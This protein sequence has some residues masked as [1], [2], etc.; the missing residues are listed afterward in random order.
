MKKIKEFKLT[1]SLNI[2]LNFCSLII[3]FIGLRFIEIDNLNNIFILL[4][5]LLLVLFLHELIHIVFYK[6]F[7]A[8]V[9]FGIKL[10]FY[11]YV[12]NILEKFYKIKEII[13][14]LISSCL[15]LSLLLYILCLFLP[16]LTVYLNLLILINISG[17]IGDIIM[18]IYLLFQ[19]KKYLVKDEKNGFSLWQ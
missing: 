12:V 7:G 17:S 5:G 18:A 13:L 2:L 9:K 1:L 16:T 6:I 14:V 8:K 19:N 3:F 11:I 10:P 15:I 4:I